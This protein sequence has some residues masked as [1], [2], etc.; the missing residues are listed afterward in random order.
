MRKSISSTTNVE[1]LKSASLAPPKR[2]LTES[3]S[4]PLADGGHDSAT[5]SWKV[6]IDFFGDSYAFGGPR[7]SRLYVYMASSLATTMSPVRLSRVMHPQSHPTSSTVFGGCP[8][9]FRDR[10]TFKILEVVDTNSVV[11]SFSSTAS[12]TPV[13]GSSDSNTMRCFVPRSWMKSPRTTTTEP[14]EN[15][16]AICLRSS[17]AASAEIYSFVSVSEDI[18]QRC[19]PSLPETASSHC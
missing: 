12:C 18:P 10:P 9:P 3:G 6:V 2:R 11:I 15:P 16:T 1:A 13:T 17:S 7:P 8:W 4:R 5:Y 19:I 14:L